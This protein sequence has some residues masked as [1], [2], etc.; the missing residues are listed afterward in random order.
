MSRCLYVR[1]SPILCE[2]LYRYKHLSQFFHLKLVFFSPL[3]PWAANTEHRVH[4][5]TFVC[6]SYMRKSH[7]S[8]TILCAQNYLSWRKR[9]KNDAYCEEQKRDEIRLTYYSLHHQIPLQNNT[10]PMPDR[11]WRK[12]KTF[13]FSTKSHINSNDFHRFSTP[14]TP[15]IAAK[16]NNKIKTN[17]LHTHNSYS[18]LFRHPSCITFNRSVHRDRGLVSVRFGSIFHKHKI[19]MRTKHDTV[20]PVQ[21]ISI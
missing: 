8:K 13:S 12:W 14:A 16:N 10:M 7:A 4:S 2:Y 1:S 17:H 3:K 19:H 6:M 18:Y 21:C 5:S 20:I 15:A 11:E 9:M